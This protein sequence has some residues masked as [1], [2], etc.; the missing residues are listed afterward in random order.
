MNISNALLLA[1]LIFAGIAT[2]P[3]GIPLLA[4]IFLAAHKS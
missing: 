2:M 1:S 4:L 3:W